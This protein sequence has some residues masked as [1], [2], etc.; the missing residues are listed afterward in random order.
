[1]GEKTSNFEKMLFTIILYEEENK[2]SY[3]LINKV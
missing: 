1:M 2:S 3:N